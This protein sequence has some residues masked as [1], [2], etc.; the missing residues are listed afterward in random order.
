M[1]RNIVKSDIS[2][3]VYTLSMLDIKHKRERRKQ[4]EMDAEV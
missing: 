4:K 2:G 1:K 3:N